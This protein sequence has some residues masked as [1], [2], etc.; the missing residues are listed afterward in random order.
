MKKWLGFGIITMWVMP[1]KSAF[2]DKIVDKVQLKTAK[3]LGLHVYNVKNQ[4]PHYVENSI[5]RFW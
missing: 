4:F 2:V 1:M 3:P 5:S